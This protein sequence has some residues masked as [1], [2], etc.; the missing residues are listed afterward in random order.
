MEGKITGYGPTDPQARKTWLLQNQPYSFVSV[1]PETGKKTFLSFSRFDPYGVPFGMAADFAQIA[2]Q[3]E[4]GDRDTFAK[5]AV[6]AMVNNL[7][8]KTYLQGLIQAVNILSDD[9]GSKLQAYMEQRAASYV[10]N[11][12]GAANPDPHL[13]EVRTVLDAMQA[14]VPGFSKSLPPRRDVLGEPITVPMGY[15]WNAINPFAVKSVDA[16]TVRDEMARLSASDAGIR[17]PMPPQK[18]DGLDLTTV[19][20]EDGVSVYDRWMQNIGELSI[21]GK[22]LHDKLSDTINSNA[23]QNAAD[24]NGTFRIS[25]KVD[26]IQDILNRYRQQALR[27]TLKE[28]PELQQA[29]REYKAGARRVRAGQTPATDPFAVFNQ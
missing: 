18:M 19:K 8:S 27:E 7:A 23:Y 26:M 21:G 22:S 11:L 1:D 17:F 14:K 15:P 9:R 5:G 29:M 3:L 4:E 28:F 20:G 2:G 13:R 25:R 12:L 16:D 24:G 6:L 10:P